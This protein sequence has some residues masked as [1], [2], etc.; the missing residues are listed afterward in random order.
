MDDI[1]RIDQSRLIVNSM[2]YEEFAH[3]VILGEM[4]ESSVKLRGGPPLNEENQTPY[5]YAFL[6]VFSELAADES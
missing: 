4:L 6:A 2:S 3:H 1:D 5:D